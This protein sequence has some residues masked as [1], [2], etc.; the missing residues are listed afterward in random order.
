M[1]NEGLPSKIDRRIELLHWHF[2]PFG[3][4]RFYFVPFS[5][6]FELMQLTEKT[7][8]SS[9]VF[10]SKANL[11]CFLKEIEKTIYFWFVRS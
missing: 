11:T 7:T 4:I 8:V 1:K 3:S 5:F 9:K 2:A 6:G 10:S